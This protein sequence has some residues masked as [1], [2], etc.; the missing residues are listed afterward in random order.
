[1]SSKKL[2]G[3]AVCRSVVYPTK[4]HQSHKS[5]SLQA[6]PYNDID[7]PSPLRIFALMATATQSREFDLSVDDYSLR[8]RTITFADDTPSARPTLVFLH[9]SLGCISVWRDFP[10]RLASVLGCNALIYDRRGYGAS[11]P[12]GP[13]PRRPDYLEEEANV[14]AQ[15][16]EACAVH[17]AL[18]FGH[19]DGGSSHSSRPLDGPS[20]SPP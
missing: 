16:L 3:L 15:V 8:V 17:D 18:L 14:L 4:S 7:A 1:M 2:V 19:S 11:T 12:F 20:S 10:D 9:D 6:V 13:E 5:A